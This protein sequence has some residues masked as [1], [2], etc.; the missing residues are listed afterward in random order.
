MVLI[1]P[2]V[3]LTVTP[4][5]LGE[6]DLAVLAE[7]IEASLGCCKLVA[8]PVQLVLR[9]VP[10]VVLQYHPLIEVPLVCDVGSHIGIYTG[11]VYEEG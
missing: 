1:S 2:R 5:K 4:S 7:V 9:V 11:P 3:G 6:Q 10:P 8:C